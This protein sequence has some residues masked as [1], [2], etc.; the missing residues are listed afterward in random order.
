MPSIIAHPAVALALGP[1]FARF[2]V[3]PRLWAVGAVGAIAPDADTLGLAAGIQYASVFG[4]RGLSHSLL[5]AA[6]LALLLVPVCRKLSPLTPILATFIFCFLCT[7]SH[8]LL[9]A[10]TD[11]GLG[12]AFFS[13]WSNDRY[14]FAWQPI[15]V[16]PLGLSRFLG[17]RG[18]SVL[19]S[20]FRWLIAP[21]LVVGL[22]AH[23]FLPARTREAMAKKSATAEAGQ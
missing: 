19:A 3:G 12:V 15:R 14:F 2:G 17:Q 7:A 10:M 8:G 6:V 23:F 16:S 4:H 20:E 11:G 5:F 21:A 1:V 9:D 18:V 13:P 22:I